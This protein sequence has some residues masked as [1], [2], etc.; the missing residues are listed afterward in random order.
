MKDI[1]TSKLIED[2]NQAAKEAEANDDFDKAIG[3]YEQN[4]TEPFHDQ[5]AF[6]RLMVIYRK[7]KEY[8]QELRV[9]K[10]GIDVFREGNKKH[11]EET[12]GSKK[13]KT[14][15]VKL[16]N[17]FMKGAGLVDKKGKE[18]YFPEPINK[19]MKRKEVVEK[20]LKK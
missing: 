11:I 3:L 17:A 18:T 9:I 13:N 16:S 1:K 7:R 12:I 15:L 19:W 10:K 4:I 20:R 5:Y 14:Q 6:E 8:K 2:R